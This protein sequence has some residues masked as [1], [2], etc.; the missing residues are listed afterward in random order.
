MSKTYKQLQDYAKAGIA[1]YNDK[2]YPLLLLKDDINRAY[3]K[4]QRDIRPLA[5]K[6]FTKEA[7]SSGAIFAVPSDLSNDPNSI[8][9]VMASNA[10]TRGYVTIDYT[11]PTADLTFTAKE[12]GTT[13]IHIVTTGG[14]GTGKVAT[15]CVYTTYWTITV[16]FEND[17]LTC[18]EILALVNA[19]PV[20]GNLVTVSTTTGSVKPAQGES[21]TGTV[22]AG[23]GANWYQAD[24][25]SIKQ[26]NQLQSDSYRAGTTLEPK[27]C[28]K[29]DGSGSRMLYMYPN[30]ITYTKL[31]YYYVVAELSS[32][33][34]TSAIPSEFEELLLIEIL[35]RGYSRLGDVARQTAQANEY[36]L[37]VKELFEKYGV[38]LTNTKVAKE[39]M[40][41]NE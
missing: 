9:D 35:K 3:Q 22:S 1:E 14:S 28:L 16:Q 15:T 17:D 5:V 32:D 36:N 12:P 27:W 11:V 6:S 8:I 31:H 39:Q 4:V 25:W 33:S 34:D 18:N 40:K 7:I 10:G 37:K 2:N 19:D 21:K 13:N 20:A 23:T 38:E 30:T 24:E 26:F 41:I 29:G